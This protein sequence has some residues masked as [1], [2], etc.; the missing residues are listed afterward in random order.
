MTNE[1]KIRDTIKQVLHNPQVT[2]PP[3]SYT[4]IERGHGED[5]DYKSDYIDKEDF[6]RFMKDLE[7]Q[8]MYRFSQ[9]LF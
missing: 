9:D 4:I 2:Y 7:K 3:T 6:K 1:K 5:K 8:L